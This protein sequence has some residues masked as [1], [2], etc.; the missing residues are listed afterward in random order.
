M[1]RSLPS[2]AQ[3]SR[4]ASSSACA[5]G[6]RSASVRL[7][8]AGQHLAVGA[9]HH[10]ADRHLAEIARGF[11]FG[12]RKRHRRFAALPRAVA[13]ASFAVMGGKVGR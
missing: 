3:A 12:K 1:S 6:S 8:A 10:R 7:P 4:M 9:H 5:V 11:G 13:S 2:L